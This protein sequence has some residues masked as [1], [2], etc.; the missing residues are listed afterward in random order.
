MMRRQKNYQ[1][2]NLDTHNL[3][4]LLLLVGIVISTIG[5]LMIILSK[6][7]IFKLPGD[8]E[9]GGKNW[10]IYFPILSCVIISII[11]TLILWIVSYLRK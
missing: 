10:R 7:G 1:M 3:G 5:L 4:K 8:I 6:C 11:L 9:I 2:P